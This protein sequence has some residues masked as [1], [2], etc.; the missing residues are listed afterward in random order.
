MNIKTQGTSVKSMVE[1]SRESRLPLDKYQLDFEV[2][3]EV[4]TAVGEEGQ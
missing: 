3:V 2:R 1:E 4:E